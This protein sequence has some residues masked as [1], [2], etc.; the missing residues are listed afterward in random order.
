MVLSLQ[1]R[2]MWNLSGKYLKAFTFHILCSELLKHY[3][4]EVDVWR[5]ILFKDSP[6]IPSSVFIL[7]LDCV[8]NC[9]QLSLW[10]IYGHKKSWSKVLSGTTTN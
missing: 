6:N 7:E 5:I 4:S 10:N 2:I 9:K 1:N 8:I 3:P